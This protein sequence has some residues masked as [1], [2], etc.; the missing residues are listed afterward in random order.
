[1]EKSMFMGF[2]HFYGLL[3]LLMQMVDSVY[4]RTII[5]FTD[6]KEKAYQQYGCKLWFGKFILFHKYPVFLKKRL[7]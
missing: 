6:R 5:I 7:I 3:K 4:T 1:M 2:F